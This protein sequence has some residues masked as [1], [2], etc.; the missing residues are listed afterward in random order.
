MFWKAKEKYRP[1]QV[2]PESGQ[3][4][5]KDSGFEVTVV[6]KKPFPPTQK[7]NQQYEYT[8]FT[9]RKKKSTRSGWMRGLPF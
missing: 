8:N 5:V 4:T 2:A 1:G 3:V 6:R 7:P 9:K